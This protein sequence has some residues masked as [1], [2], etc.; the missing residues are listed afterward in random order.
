VP[1][2]TITAAFNGQV[3]SSATAVS[4]AVQ[5]GLSDGHDRVMHM[6]ANELRDALDKLYRDLEAKHGRA[7]PDGTSGSSL[8]VR[9]GAGLRS[10][11]DSIM[12]TEGKDEATGTITT[13]KMTVH[14]TGATITAKHAKYLTIPLNAALNSHGIPLRSKARDWDNTFIARTKRGNLIIFQRNTGGKVTPLYLLRK[15][16]TLRARL[17]MTKMF[18]DLIPYFERKAI[19][20]VEKAYG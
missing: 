4:R 3:F 14:E 1:Q 7:W 13:G 5:K 17:G 19:E 6:I 10:I 20:A 16:V 9:S 2:L 12:V 18:E 8:S 15:S 11:K